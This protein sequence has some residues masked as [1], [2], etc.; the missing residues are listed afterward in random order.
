MI[1]EKFFP[2]LMEELAKIEATPED[3]RTEADMWLVSAVE[4]YAAFL[5]RA[6]AGDHAA[7]QYIDWVL[8]TID[9]YLTASPQAALDTFMERARKT[10]EQLVQTA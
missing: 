5:S 8:S 2:R 1:P 10:A 3:E 6:M 7:R 4:E 9:T